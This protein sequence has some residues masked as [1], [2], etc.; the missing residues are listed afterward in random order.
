MAVVL[1]QYKSVC[2]VVV[3]LKCPCIVENY[4]EVL[5][6]GKCCIVENNLARLKSAMSRNAN[7]NSFACLVHVCYSSLQ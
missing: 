6:R 7:V 1:V 5:F 2:L 3:L 4:G